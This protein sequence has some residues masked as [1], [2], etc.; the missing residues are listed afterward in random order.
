MGDGFSQIDG[1]SRFNI[2]GT[3]DMILNSFIEEID[4]K[5]KLV[6]SMEN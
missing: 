3:T 6:K 1:A 5:I 4:R 2:E